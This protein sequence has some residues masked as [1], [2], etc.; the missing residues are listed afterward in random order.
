MSRFILITL[1]LILTLPWP[2]QSIPATTKYREYCST[3]AAELKISND[4]VAPPVD[5]IYLADDCKYCG[6]LRPSECERY[7]ISNGFKYYSCSKC[8]CWC[9][10]VGGL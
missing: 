5:S 2:T 6:G 4:E 10:G 9:W 8:G 1:F 7:C 3:S